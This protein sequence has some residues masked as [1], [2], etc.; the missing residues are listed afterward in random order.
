MSVITTKGLTKRFGKVEALRGI[1]LTVEQG[2]V[3]GFIGPNGAGKSTTIRVLLGILRASGGTAHVFGRDCWH[4]AV[5]I[6]ERIAYVPGEMNVWQNLSGGEM[7]DLLVRMRGGS[8]RGYHDELVERF[9]F[10]PTKKC[11]SYSKGNKQK[12]ALI[13]AFSSDADL[14]VLDE[15]TSG[16]DP[17]MELVFK[18]CV[19]KVKAAGKTVFLSSHILSEVE[20]LCTRISVIKEGCIV[21]SG[22]LQE[23]RHLTRNSVTVTTRT[24]PA[25]VL[26]GLQA[27][28]GVHAAKVLNGQIFFHMDNNA[29]ASVMGYLTSQGVEYLTSTPPTLEELF[30]QHY[31][32]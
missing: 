32:Q 20:Q 12:I 30:I 4:D 31:N 1:D 8:D 26:D 15:P 25:T 9:D 29:T 2:E 6:H 21:D 3:Y 18:D 22:T 17:L 14:F 5:G 16:L 13:A 28:V 23:M 24:D 11:G 27:L 19:Q 7:I 10:D